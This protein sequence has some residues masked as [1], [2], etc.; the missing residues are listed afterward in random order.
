V[1]TANEAGR[2]ATAGER[3][4]TL[5][6][7]TQGE[8]GRRN[9]FV[10]ELIHRGETYRAVAKASGLSVAGVAGIVA[11]ARRRAAALPGRR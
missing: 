3:V 4:R 11:R 7:E 10:R 1:I 9:S 5:H 2:L 8:R 6:T